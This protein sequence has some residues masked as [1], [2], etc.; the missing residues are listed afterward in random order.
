MQI[1]AG[2]GELS[3]ARKKMTQSD[4]RRKVTT[5]AGNVNKEDKELNAATIT[6]MQTTAPQEDQIA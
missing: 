4:E 3:I 5:A 2:Q 1:S 6:E